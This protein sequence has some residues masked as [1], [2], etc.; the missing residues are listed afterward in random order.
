MAPVAIPDVPVYRPYELQSP[1][2]FPS[3]CSTLS[4]G[5]C[6]PHVRRVGMPYRTRLP[7]DEATTRVT[8]V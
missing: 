7:R 6:A 4:P 3:G 8:P 5:P 2:C 1:R